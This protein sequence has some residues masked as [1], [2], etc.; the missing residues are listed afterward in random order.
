MNN[1]KCVYSGNI[2]DYLGVTTG[3]IYKVLKSDKFSVRFLDD[4]ESESELYISV[5]SE[6]WFEDATAEIRNNKI[7]QLL[8]F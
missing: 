5:G 6:I 3:K 8:E 1:I 7:K 4:R 2:P